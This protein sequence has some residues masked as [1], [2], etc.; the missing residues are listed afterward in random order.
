MKLLN[1]LMWVVQFGFSCIFPTL[2]FL[3]LAV[4][5]QNK[6]GLGAWIVIVLGLLGVLTS[7]STTR[8]CLR[9]L[10]KAASEACEDK[11]PPVAFNDHK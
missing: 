3:I 7:I 10:R 5:L 2:F 6:F 4:W 8:S 1:L 11:E 9:A